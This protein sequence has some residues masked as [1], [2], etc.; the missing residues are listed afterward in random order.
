MKRFA[1]LGLGLVIAANLEAVYP[2]PYHDALQQ[3]AKTK[4]L[5]PSLGNEVEHQGIKY[6]VVEVKEPVIRGGHKDK[7]ETKGDTFVTR[8]I[9]CEPF[10]K[11]LK[12]IEFCFVFKIK[13][14]KNGSE[15]AFSS[16]LEDLITVHD[17]NCNCSNY[18]AIYWIQSK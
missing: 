11:D 15:F 10:E 4:L 5:L 1:I 12:K 8:H 13:S 6:R 16:R 3:F 17:G 14:N 7:P 2:N 18:W 9:V